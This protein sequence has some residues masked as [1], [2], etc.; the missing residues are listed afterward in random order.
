MRIENWLQVA[1]KQLLDENVLTA[2]LDCLVLLGDALGKDKGWILAHSEY[3]LQGLEIKKLNTK[4]TQ[5]AKHIPLAY[6][7]GKAEFYG[8]EF[9]V[10]EHTLVPRPETETIIS[11]LTALPPA[12]TATILDIGTGSGCLAITAALELPN[13]AV[14]A[15]DIDERCL[16][17]AQQNALVLGA[18][19]ITFFASN[20][21]EYAKPCDIILANLPY[22]PND[23]HINTAASHEPKHA[24]FGGADGLD[25]YRRMFEQITANTWQ[26]KYVLTESL[27]PQHEALAGLA[28]VAGYQLVKT[29][30]FIQL[31]SC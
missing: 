22:V 18:T 11:M 1:T 3:I 29:D 28:K 15:C 31:F 17:T 23:F 30:D 19:G 13:A 2:R 9:A 21:L 26:P 20:L 14:Q 25:L 8:R 10:N 24:I 27:P 6:L 5:R 7:R 12:T 16:A 4:I